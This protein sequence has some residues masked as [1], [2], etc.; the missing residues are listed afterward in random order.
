MADEGRVRG[1]LPAAETRTE[2]RTASDDLPESGMGLLLIRS[3]MDEVS[4]ESGAHADTVVKMFKRLPDY[5]PSP[6][7]APRA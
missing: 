3:L 2:A 1:G 4:H 6:L 5:R 7:V